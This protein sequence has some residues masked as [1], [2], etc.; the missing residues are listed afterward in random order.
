MLCGGVGRRMHPLRE[1]EFAI[2]FLGKPLL[3][4]IVDGLRE[5]SIDEVVFVANDTNRELVSKMALQCNAGACHVVTQEGRDGMAGAIEA[6]AE[7][8]RGRILIVSSNDV[9]AHAAY[10]AVVEAASDS[11]LD[12]AML[13]YRVEDHFAGGY[14][15]TDHSMRVSHIME[16]PQRGSEP[17]NLV[18]IVVHFHRDGHKLLQSVRTTVSYNDDCYERALTELVG[19]GY[20]IRAVP[21]AGFWGALKRPWDVFSVVQ[22]FLSGIGPAVATNAVVT[23]SAIIE[24][25]VVLAD[26]V[27]VLEHAVIRGPAYIG[28]RSVIGNNALIRGG[29][30][31][32]AR[33]VVGFSTEVK[34]SYIGDDCWFHSNY[35]GDSIID[36]GC[37][38]GSGCVTANLRFDKGVV[39]ATID[40][41]H[42][43]TGQA[44]LGVIMGR[45]CQVGINASLYPGVMVGPDAIVGPNVRLTDDLGPGMFAKPTANYEAVAHHDAFAPLDR[46]SLLERLEKM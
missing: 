32:G 40:G 12:G 41:A 17:S 20:C 43:D 11:D 15:V 30:H 37:S 26:N 31:I 35:I 29:V 14:L 8:L 23:P 38:F 3:Q 16:K 42:S 34:N 6:A 24:G 5:A 1:D 7:Y 2:G 25:D 39:R 46:S 44:K 4:H 28:E 9:V 21:Y 19:D 36:D 22:H 13:A 45:H 33:S 10:K 18:N 27:H